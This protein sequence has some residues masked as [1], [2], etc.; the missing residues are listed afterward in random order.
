MSIPRQSFFPSG[1]RVLLTLALAC[2]VVPSLA[3]QRDG[4]RM[5]A[6]SLR[7]AEATRVGDYCS[8]AEE[9]LAPPEV[10]Q[11][12]GYAAA[13]ARADVAAM[14]NPA[15]EQLSL[16]ELT[17][18][19]PASFS[20][21]ARVHTREF[22]EGAR[23]IIVA[24]T[25]FRAKVGQADVA[26][27]VTN[28][29]SPQRNSAWLAASGT[30]QASANVESV[31]GPMVRLSKYE[32]KLG[33]TSP[34]LNGAEVVVNFL[35]QEVL[36]G[37][38]PTPLGGPGHWEFIASYAPAYVTRINK[39]VTPV[40]GAEFGLRHYMF[41]DGFG[42]SGIGGIFFPS[43][44]SVGALTASNLNGALIYPWRAH[45]RTGGFVAW[46]SI[47]VGYIKRGR[48]SWMVSKQF[49]AIPFVF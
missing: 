29:L 46:G 25:D 12:L 9:I 43:Y 45:E 26:S 6:I 15:Y 18:G 17:A 14:C 7:R 40:A 42:K 41:G 44:W 5:N 24:I 3:A 2:A 28:A 48:G 13:A 31:D 36:P 20:E 19:A 8:L 21:V 22:A 27:A 16:L 10:I 35:A 34:R 30:W 32:R 33:P 11:R 23:S 47:K 38:K 1:T 49:Q 37:F 4:D 39:K